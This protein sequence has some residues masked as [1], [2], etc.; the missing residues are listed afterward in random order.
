M[1]KLFSILL[2]ATF[3]LFTAGCAEDNDDVRV[4]AGNLE[5]NDFVWKAMN[6]FY[7][8][9]SQVPNLSVEDFSSNQEYVNYLNAFQTPEDLFDALTIE[10]DRFS[11]IVDDYRVL[12]ASLQGSSLANGMRFGLVG[13]S[14]TNL[15]FGVVRY[16]V[17]NSSAAMQ[18]VERGMVFTQIDGVQ[19]TDSN[20]V[21]LLSPASY[22]I[23]LAELNNQSLALTGENITLVKEDLSENPIHL[24]SIIEVNGQNVGYLMY[25]NFRSNFESELNQVFADFKAN[26]VTDLILDLRYNGGGSVATANDLASMITGQFNGQVFGIQVFNENFDDVVIN[27]ENQTA[28]GELVNSL[29]LDRV[30]VLT[31]G[32]TASASELIINA[33]NPYIDVIQIGTTTTGK[34]QGSTTLYDSEDFTK[35]NVNINH[36]YALQ[37]LILTIANADGFTGFEDGLVPD[38][39]FQEDFFNYG[40]LGDPSE[41]LLARALQEIGA[42]LQG[43]GQILE[44]KSAHSLQFKLID[45]SGSDSPD[46]Q[47]MYV[48]MQ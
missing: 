10:T 41:P 37:P 21:D 35:N 11:V 48:E 47:R 13:I 38:I 20:F 28:D 6:I 40:V 24:S 39:E 42:G 7:F 14:G 31:T 3:T 12:E 43:Q 45:E 2:L 4:P 17:P 23:G 22:T 27:F 8:Y 25:N 18:G 16:V 29:N 19:L 26:A 33:L 44:Q 34:F 5:I 36:F 32:S 9:K 30:F 1:K 15:V 46:Y